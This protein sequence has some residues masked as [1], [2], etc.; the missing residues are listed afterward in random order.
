MIKCR[1]RKELCFFPVFLIAVCFNALAQKNEFGLGL[2]TH[3]YKGDIS[4]GY[5]FKFVRPAG[6]IFYRRNF[7]PAVAMRF[8]F[9]AG[10]LAANGS[11]SNNRYI[12][13]VQPN[14]FKTMLLDLSVMGEYNFL[15]FR[16]PKER[17]RWT[18]YLF[19]GITAF[20][21]QPKSA[22]SGGGVSPI[23]PAIPIGIGVKYKLSKNWNLGAEF[24]A[25]CTFTDYLDN[26]S[27][28][29]AST[30]LQRGFI[31]DKDWYMFTGLSLSYTIYTI[32][33]PN[34]SSYQY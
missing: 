12:A 10:R 5:N 15:N 16:D 11:S 18:P 33:C 22:E 7:S 24:G 31:Q 30:G 32:E 23:Q 20:Y 14:S 13:N 29:D 1:F 26:V 25:R 9:A 28:K 21:F 6:E 8:N 34:F 17:I 19:G 4:S 27:D 3:L 2:G